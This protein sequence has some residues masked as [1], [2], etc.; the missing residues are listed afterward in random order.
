MVV[1]RVHC[2]GIIVLPKGVREEAGV[3]GGC[4]WKSLLR[5]GRLC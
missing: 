1:V 3:E 5:V 2:K 4:C